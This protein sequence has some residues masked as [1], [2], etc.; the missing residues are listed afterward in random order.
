M[1]TVRLRVNNF[2]HMNPIACKFAEGES[3]AHRSCKLEGLLAGRP[4][5]APHVRPKVSLIIRKLE[6]PIHGP[7]TA[8]R[9]DRP[10]PELEATQEL[11]RVIQKP[12]LLLL[13]ARER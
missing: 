10:M 2:A 7:I 5:A 11:L 4:D 3:E 8:L 12:A 9:K 13:L 1:K 6:T